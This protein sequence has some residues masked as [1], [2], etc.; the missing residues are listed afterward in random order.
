MKQAGSK[1]S[2]S[3]VVIVVINSILGAGILTL[4]RTISKAVK[5][6]DV[7]ISVIVSGVLVALI[8]V[9][10][11]TLCRRFP[12]K[13]VFEF[14]PEI[15]GKWISYVVGLLIIIYFVILCS[16]EVR[17]MAEITSMYILER[18]PSWVTIMVSLWV[19]IYMISGGLKV[20]IRVFEI[21]LPVTLLLLAVVFLLSSRMFELSN[22]RPL[23]GEGLLPVLKGIKP[24]FLSYSGYEVLLIIT[25][26]MSDVK[27]SNKAAIYS[28]LIC[29]IIYLVTIVMVVGNLS[30]P[31]IESRT[32]PTLDMVRSFEIE[33]IFFERYESLFIVFWLLQI[34]ATYAFKHYFAAVGIRDLFSLRKITGIEYALLPV[35]YIIAYLPKNLE[36]TL[37]LGD[38]LG[39]ISI[40]LF[41]LL[42]LLLLIISMIRKKGGKHTSNEGSELQSQ[43]Q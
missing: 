39:N 32:W 16:F 17:V 25:A 26:L 34:F 38:F 33:G 13:S 14:V 42:P 31:G 2:T 37:A 12:G 40:F 23:L 21:V 11:V 19:G 7:W 10:L 3:E 22:L 5:T 36:E 28:I 24:S 35:L 41:G 15:T 1:I 43:S 4:P 20:I 30:L 18:T 6:P 29:T 8:S 9:L 27:T